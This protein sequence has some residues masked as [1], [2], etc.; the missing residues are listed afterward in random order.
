MY[1][2]VPTEKGGLASLNRLSDTLTK[3]DLE[4]LFNRM[5]PKNVAIQL[6]KFRIQQKLFLKVKLSPH[7]THKS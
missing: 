6:P 5:E 4:Q 7:Q 3:Q 1:L 2:I